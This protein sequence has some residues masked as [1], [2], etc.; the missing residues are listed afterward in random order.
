M[1]RKT[2]VVTYYIPNGMVRYNGG[3]YLFA[4]DFANPYDGSKMTIGINATSEEDNRQQE[5]VPAET[6][7]MTQSLDIPTVYKIKKEKLP[8]RTIH[9]EKFVQEKYKMRD[10]QEMMRV[11]MRY[12]M[13]NFAFLNI[14]RKWEILKEFIYSTNKQI[15]IKK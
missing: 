5:I 11:A 14:M 8:K 9:L 7:E 10:K 12:F 4:I 6:P 3:T 1:E 13:K 15:W 2:K